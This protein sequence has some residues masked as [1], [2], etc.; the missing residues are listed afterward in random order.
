MAEKSTWGGVRPGAGRKP[1][2]IRT[3]AAAKKLIERAK[4]ADAD[5]PLDALW[6]AATSFEFVNS[7]IEDRVEAFKFQMDCASRVCPYLFPR[8]SAVAVKN[9]ED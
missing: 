9:E 2:A 8:Y 1:S 3:A 4:Q 6:R 5:T 7:Y